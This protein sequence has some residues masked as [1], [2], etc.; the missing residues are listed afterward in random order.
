[1]SISDVGRFE[2]VGI[3]LR[4]RKNARHKPEPKKNET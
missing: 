3:G 2:N 4:A 1:V